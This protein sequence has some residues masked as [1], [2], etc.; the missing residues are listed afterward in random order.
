MQPPI[1]RMNSGRELEA[2]WRDRRLTNRRVSFLRS[3][4]SLPADLCQSSRSTVN[5]SAWI[6]LYRIYAN[7]RKRACSRFRGK[8]RLSLDKL[9][10]LTRSTVLKV[11]LSLSKDEPGERA[12][13]LLHRSPKNRWAYGEDRAH[14]A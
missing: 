3:R 5:P 11:I 6:R 12:S 2:E 9:G 1:A 4:Y 14:F 8:N 13:R 10:T 7:C